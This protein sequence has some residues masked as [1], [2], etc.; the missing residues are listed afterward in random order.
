[1]AGSLLDHALA[2]QQAQMYDTQSTSCPKYRPFTSL[3]D[4]LSLILLRESNN[5]RR[6]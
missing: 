1:M 6:R 2:L 4:Q 3:F 5:E